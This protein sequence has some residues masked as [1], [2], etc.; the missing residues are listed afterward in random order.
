[1]WEPRAVV[2]VEPPVQQ[3]GHPVELVLGEGVPPTTQVPC[4]RV[5]LVPVGT[6]HPD[7]RGDR[8]GNLLQQ[9]GVKFH[10][11]DLL[12]ARTLDEC[13]HQVQVEGVGLPP[14]PRVGVVEESDR[15][16][17]AVRGRDLELVTRD[18]RLPLSVCTDG[19]H[20]VGGDRSLRGV[21]REELDELLR[22]DHV[23]AHHIERSTRRLLVPEATSHPLVDQS[24][25]DLA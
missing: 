10:G 9:R 20:G 12:G 23:T 22:G 21:D 15:G 18:T 24:A 11:L 7:V 17:I 6:E 25:D 1:M 13:V 19:E 3:R 4:S 14:G 8:G 16:R 5:A 2:H